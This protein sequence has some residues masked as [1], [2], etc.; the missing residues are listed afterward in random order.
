MQSHLRRG[1]LLNS[2]KR[3]RKTIN[4]FCFDNFGSL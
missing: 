2:I 4:L 1:K 3:E